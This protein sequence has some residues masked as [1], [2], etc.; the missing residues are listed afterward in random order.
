MSDS[1]RPH[2]PEVSMPFSALVARKVS[3]AEQPANPLAEAAVQ[4]G[5]DKLVNA[6]WPQGKARVY[7]L[8]RNYGGGFHI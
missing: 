4:A 1:H 2:L 6:P 8:Q 3:R 5:L 7:I